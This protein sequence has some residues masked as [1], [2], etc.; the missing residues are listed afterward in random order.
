MGGLF[1]VIMRP[2]VGESDPLLSYYLFRE[3]TGTLAPFPPTLHTHNITGYGTRQ[4]SSQKHVC[5]HSNDFPGTV[6]AR[7]MVLVTVS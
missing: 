2:R 1:V 4:P 3:A 5:L 7:I 6:T